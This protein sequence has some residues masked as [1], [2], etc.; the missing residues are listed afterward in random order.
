MITLKDYFGPRQN[1][2]EATPEKYAAADALLNR[3]NGLLERARKEASY[4]E[5]VDADTNTQ[6]SGSRGGS[7]DGGF[8]SSDSKTGAGKS[9]HKLARA[10]DVY[11]PGDVLDNWLTN[12][13][14]EEEG[15]YR[16]H[17]DSTPG[18]CH[19]QDLAPGSGNRTFHP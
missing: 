9:K 17:P 8:R 11:D 10:V 2:P 7:G 18:W 15:L 16:E 13:I 1:H 14:L 5:D 19:L 12:K 3:V 4:G 6:V